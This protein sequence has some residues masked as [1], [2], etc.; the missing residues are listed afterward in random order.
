LGD[1][2]GRKFVAQAFG[3]DGK[4]R[5][6]QMVREIERSMAEDI[7]SLSWMSSETK[8]Q[9]LKKLNAVTNKISYPDKWR[10]YST[11]NIADD[12]YFGNWYRANEYESRRN[13][14]KI[15]KLVDRSEWSMTPPTVDA[16]YDPSQNNINFPAGI[17][18][19]PFYSNKA[20]DA[21]NYGAIGAVIGRE[22]THAFDDEGRKFDADGNLKDWWQP[23]DAKRYEHLSACLADE[24]GAFTVLPK[25]HLNGQFTLGENTADNGGLRLA[26]HALMTDLASKSIP[27]T[28]KTRG[29]TRAQQFFLGFSQIWCASMRPESLRQLVQTDPHSPLQFRVNGAVVNSPDFSAAFGSKQGDKMYAAQPCRVW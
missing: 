10:D 16:Y 17:L 14:S 29:Y 12:D 13:R 2:L 1:A 21:V 11:V 27:E 26:Y 18:E 8:E 23:Q 6:L 15:G 24:Y 20:A 9:A 3:K 28:Q 5:T 22:L 7:Q 4:E 19:P 25:L